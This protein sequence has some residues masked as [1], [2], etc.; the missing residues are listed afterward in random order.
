VAVLLVAAA[1]LAPV[2]VSRSVRAIDDEESTA[3]PRY[4]SP[5]TLRLGLAI[6]SIV[7]LVAIAVPLTTASDVRSSQNEINARN[8]SAA[9]SDAESAARVEPGAASPQ[10]Q[11]ALVLEQQQRFSAGVTAAAKATRNESQNW[12]NWLVLSRLEAEAGQPKASVAAYERA[13]SLNPWSP[14][15]HR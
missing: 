10:L 15:F 12:S 6:A 5:L 9:L 2:P 14:V 8:A 7:A 1:L 3:E 11:L 13:R 4:R